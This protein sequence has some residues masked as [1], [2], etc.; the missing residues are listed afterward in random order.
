MHH[1]AIFSC[2]R[3]NLSKNVVH[4]VGR[5]S[6]VES[7]QQSCNFW[8]NQQLQSHWILPI[9]VKETEL[10]TLYVHLQASTNLFLFQI[11]QQVST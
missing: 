7:W 4:V 2:G 5:C 3:L 6:A 1:E 10:L 8:R 9:F 11:N